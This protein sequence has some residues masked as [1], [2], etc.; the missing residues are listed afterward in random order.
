MAFYFI[1]KFE[2][3]SERTPPNLDIQLFY[4]GN[5]SHFTW[6]WLVFRNAL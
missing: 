5:C 2:I 4:M 1:Y 3:V 6:V